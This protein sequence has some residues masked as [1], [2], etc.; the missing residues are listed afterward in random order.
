MVR[1]RG[2]H[3]VLI[4]TAVFFLSF[5]LLVG[6]YYRL[7]FYSQDI[8]AADFSSKMT[9]EVGECQ[10]TMLRRAMVRNGK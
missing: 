3:G 2:E 10:G 1:K 9:L 6:N 4:L 8:P 5:T 7:A